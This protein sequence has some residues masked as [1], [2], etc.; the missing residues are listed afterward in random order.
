M[1]ATARRIVDV[2]QPVFP[3]VHWHWHRQWQVGDIE[4]E[5]LLVSSSGFSG[6][7][8]GSMFGHVC[9]SKAVSVAAID[10]YGRDIV[11]FEGVYVVPETASVCHLLSILVLASLTL[12]VI[13]T[14]APTN[15][16][17][18]GRGHAT[19]SRK[20]ATRLALYSHFTALAFPKHAPLYPLPRNPKT[21]N[22]MHTK[23]ISLTTGHS[24]M[25]PAAASPRRA[26]VLS[27][28]LQILRRAQFSHR[29]LE[30]LAS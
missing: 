7:S 17:G 23:F 2:C 1:K 6:A 27:L 4:A 26:A 20:D 9:A 13:H 16:S 24:S 29:L 8:D 30:D 28:H 19:C 11:A 14:P 5:F 21:R 18:S 3:V 10:W 25:T 22:S 12:S 15:S